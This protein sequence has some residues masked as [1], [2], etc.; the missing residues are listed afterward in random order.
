VQA[1]LS[2]RAPFTLGIMGFCILLYLVMSLTGGADG[3]ELVAFGAKLN[4]RIQEGEWWRLVTSNF[5]HAP[6][7]GLPLHLLMNMWAL[8]N[9]G[10]IVEKLYGSSKFVVLWLV[11][12]LAGSVASYFTV[13]P[14]M[15]IGTIASFIFRNT[16]MP[17]VGASGA[18]FGLIGVLV[19]FG[20]KY[21]HE[22][23]DGFK[24]S[25][26]TGLFP[27]ILIN[28]GIGFWGRSFIENSAHLG[29]LISGIGLALVIDYQR[30]NRSTTWDGIWRVLQGLALAVVVVSFFMVWRHYSPPPKQESITAF[31]VSVNQGQRAMDFFPDKVDAAGLEKAQSDL[32]ALPHITPS[33]DHLVQGLR[34]LLQRAQ[35]LQ[36]AAT[37]KTISPADQALLTSLTNDYTA[38]AKERDAWFAREGNTLG[39]TLDKDDEPEKPAGK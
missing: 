18:L 33:A 11:T 7:G 13:R 4:N 14:S 22:L 34:A 36:P 20:I 10:P 1:V 39:L 24:R 15:Q 9:F 19:V 3:A 31:M 17:S 26:G 23:P 2:R 30:A 6:I 16:D 37:A 12:G 8:W 21:R 25:F 29:G 35:K 28:L 32:G 27:I 38:W 5:L